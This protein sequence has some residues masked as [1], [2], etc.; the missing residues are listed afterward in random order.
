MDHD[1]L[2]EWMGWSFSKRMGSSIS[3]LWG[4]RT[5]SQESAGRQALSW[6]EALV[7]VSPWGLM[8]AGVGPWVGQ[9]WLK[10]LHCKEGRWPFEM[11]VGW[12]MAMKQPVGTL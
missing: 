2:W 7:T 11:I 4:D 10:V 8:C 5:G 1:V 3:T 12:E 9:T 6:S